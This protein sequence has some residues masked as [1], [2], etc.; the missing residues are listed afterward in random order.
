[1]GFHLIATRKQQRAA[2]H[3]QIDCA[4]LVI[5]N[6]VCGAATSVSATIDSH[7][8]IIF[9]P[10]ESTDTGAALPGGRGEGE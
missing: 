1:M 5:A 6:R 3:K 8:R 4:G 9:K 10:H 2:E 7:S